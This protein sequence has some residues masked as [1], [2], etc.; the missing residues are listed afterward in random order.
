MGQEPSM[1]QSFEGRNSRTRLRQY[2]ANETESLLR[3]LDYYVFAAGLA[4]GDGVR[5]EAIELLNDVVVE[6][7]EHA[8]RFDPNGQPR[9]WLQGIA[10]NLIK[11]RQAKRARLNWREPLVR[12]MY[13]NDGD[14][15]SDDEIF[16]YVAT[17][18]DTA[19]DPSRMME[20][21]EDV[22][23]LLEGLPANEQQ[24]LQLAIVT[25]LDG[26][27]LAR[28]LGISPGAAR[29]RLHRA[30]NKLRHIMLE[31]R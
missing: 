7:L 5:I 3:T 24:V 23:T 18:A 25:E 13:E 31:R 8:D 2:I 15:I 17:L 22:A 1:S 10:A 28:E 4:T 30:L 19:A 12:D 16:D 20:S 26:K 29:V 6:A 11:R 21:D 14:L 27:A 9:A